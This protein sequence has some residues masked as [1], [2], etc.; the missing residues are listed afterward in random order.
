M[1][2][3]ASVAVRLDGD[4][5]R[6]LDPVWL[7]GWAPVDFALDDGTTR[8][9]AMGAGPA[10]VLIPPLPGFKEAWIACAAALAR[11]FRVVTFDLRVRFDGPPR[12]EPLLADLE[13]VLDAHAPG[14][15][16]IVGHSLGGALAQHYALAHP[17][18]VRALVLSSSFARVTTPRGDRWARFVE[19]PFVLAGQ[20]MLPRAVALSIAR[21]LA[22]RGGW[23][24]DARCD[25]RVLDFVRH[26]IRATP[27]GVATR[28]VDLAYRHDLRE[29]LGAIAC[30]TLVLHGARESRFIHQASDE[31]ARLIRG[32]QRAVS[33]GVGHLHP[34][35]GAEWLVATIEEWMAS[36]LGA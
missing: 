33:P 22:A 13:R 16:G 17:E 15:L 11:R 1:N 4:W 26:C 36:R 6:H 27:V 29:R 10:L 21:R 3:R 28:M 2:D 20:R 18:R 34:L 7:D 32:A 24:F 14:D 23:V 30:P 12:W 35:S 9:V 25:A 8:V 19:Q 5:R 31:L